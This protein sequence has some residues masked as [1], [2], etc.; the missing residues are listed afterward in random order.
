MSCES[1]QEVSG[2]IKLSLFILL[3]LLLVEL[4][5]SCP[6]FEKFTFQTVELGFNLSVLSGFLKYALIK[7]LPM[8]FFTLP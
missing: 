2:C 6:C 1:R 7:K 5:F 4:L 3:V 8:Q